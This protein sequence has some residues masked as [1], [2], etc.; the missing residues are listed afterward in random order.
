MSITIEAIDSSSDDELLTLL[1]QELERRLPADKGSP[2]FLPH[3]RKL[4]IGLRAMAVTHELDVSLALDDLGWHFG[5]WHDME[6][7]Q[8]TI[9][10][11]ELLGAKELADLFRQA[12][13][14]AKGFWAELGD[15]NWMEWYP[16]SPF[17]QA[18]EPLT[19]KAWSILEDKRIGILKYWVDHARRYPEQVGAADA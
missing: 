18:V 19:K 16:D 14:I 7:A 13:E 12:F 17:E 15:E 6:L 11:L 9:H 10:G 1:S 2:E 5:N 4:P 3:V 8:E